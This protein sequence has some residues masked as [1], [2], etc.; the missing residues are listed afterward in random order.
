M[1]KKSVSHSRIQE[2]CFDL[3]LFRTLLWV[4]LHRKIVVFPDH[5]A[6]TDAG[7]I[8]REGDGSRSSLS[9]D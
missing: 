6:C 9:V 4:G 5:T 1:H 8:I 7:N 2:L 3:W